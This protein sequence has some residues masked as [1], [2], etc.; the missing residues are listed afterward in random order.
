MA[1]NLITNAEAEYGS[2]TVWVQDTMMSWF[3]PSRFAKVA[4]VDAAKAE[5]TWQQIME[6]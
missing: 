6:N 1:P 5:E 3:S 4:G 2:G